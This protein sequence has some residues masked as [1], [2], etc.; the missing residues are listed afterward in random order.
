MIY[1]LDKSIQQHFS[2]NKTFDE[3]MALTGTTVRDKDGRHTFEF[4]LGDKAYFIKIFHGIGWKEIFKELSKGRLPILNAANEWRT[5]NRLHQLGIN[6]M[7]TMACGVRSF[8]PAGQESFLITKKIENTTTLKDLCAVWPQQ[9]PSF[10][11]K[12]YLL[13]EVANMVKRLHQSGINHRDLY[14]C[15]FRIKLDDIETQKP[16]LY[17]MDLHRA[18]RRNAVPMRWLVKDLGALYFSAADIGLTKTDWLRFIKTYTGK[19]LRQVFKEQDNLW[20]Q[21]RLRAEKFYRRDWKR[22]MPQHF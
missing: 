22:P 14:I 2:Q 20:H 18:Q 15:H 7:T 11:F 19:P 5:I 9:R 12:C 3:I 13:S 4:T 10:R 1:Q 16:P 8:N 6:T 21:V 17:L